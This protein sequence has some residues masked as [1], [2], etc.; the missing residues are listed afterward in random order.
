MREILERHWAKTVVVFSDSQAAIQQ[1]AH[2][3]LGPG[4]RLTRLIN[5]SAQALLAYSIKTEIHS[6][7]R[8]SGI[9]GNQ[10]ADRQVNVA[11]NASGDPVREWPDT[12]G[13]NIARRISDARSAE[14]ARGEAEK[15]SKHFSFRLKGNA[16]TKR[17][18]LMPSVKA[19]A[20]RFYQ[21][22]S[23]HAPTG[24][25]LKPFGHREDDKCWWCKG[26]VAQM[27]E[28]LFHHCSQWR[29]QLSTLWKVV[30]NAK[31]WKA[32]RYRHLQVCGLF[33]M[34]QLLYGGVRSSSRVCAGVCEGVYCIV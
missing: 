10:A 6:V 20:A 27:R 8:H 7:P 2:L 12:S 21:L 17:P 18:I 32:G 11:S 30:G 33:S 1:T 25:Y 15:Y 28:P 14:K 16:G 24:V 22:K 34:E 3:E 23:E 4:E 5:R 29:D 26:K 13:S 31:G 9:P 19:L